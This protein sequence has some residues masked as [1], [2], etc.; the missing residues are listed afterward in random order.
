MK[1]IGT[2]KDCK[3]WNGQETS[4]GRIGICKVP[5]KA[6]DGAWSPPDY[7]CIHWESK[8]KSLDNY[9]TKTKQD[10]EI[11]DLKRE[12][13]AAFQRIQELSNFLVSLG[14]DP[15]A[16]GKASENDEIWLIWIREFPKIG[17]DV[18]NGWICVECETSHTDQRKIKVRKYKPIE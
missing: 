3:W 2:C 16:K 5:I 14:Y 7:G 13:D 12:N 6:R 9:P 1:T 17:E 8:S 15:T 4:D 11:E 10:L 18:G